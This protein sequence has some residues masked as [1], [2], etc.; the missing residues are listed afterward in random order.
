MLSARDAFRA[1]NDFVDYRKQPKAYEW[2]K[3][4]WFKFVM[5]NPA[6]RVAALEY[7]DLHHVVT[8]YKTDW[9]GEFEIAAW[10]LGAGCGRFWFAWVM[11]LSS[12]SL[13]WL[14]PRRYYRA[15]K[16][17]RRSRSLYGQPMAAVLNW[18]VADAK[19]FVEGTD[20]IR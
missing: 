6:A 3:F 12:L 14:L 19:R 1:A 9:R 4:G 8:G 20:P 18:S 16:R 5:P 7:H 2:V 15:F 17:G 11:N 13:A 10:E